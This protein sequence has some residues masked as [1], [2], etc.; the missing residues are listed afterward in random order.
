MIKDIIFCLSFP[1]KL[2]TYSLQFHYLSKNQETVGTIY[3]P[4]SP[5]NFLEVLN[6][7]NKTDSINNENFILGDFNIN[8]YLNELVF[9]QKEHLE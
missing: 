3:R 5:S 8:L 4:Q 7:I 9:G 1:V 6:N 2:K